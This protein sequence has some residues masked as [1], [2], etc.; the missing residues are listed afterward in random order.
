MDREEEG[1]IRGGKGCRGQVSG[2]EI[3][4]VNS[5]SLSTFNSFLNHN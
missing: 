1:D 5:I 2:R 3:E 4:A